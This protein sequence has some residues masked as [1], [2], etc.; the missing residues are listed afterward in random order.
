MKI[1]WTPDRLIV[2]KFFHLFC[3]TNVFPRLYSITKFAVILAAGANAVLVKREDDANVE[4][5]VVAT[6]VTYSY[7]HNLSFVLRDFEYF[8]ALQENHVLRMI[9]QPK[10]SCLCHFLVSSFTDY[11]RI[12]LNN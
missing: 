10:A 12:I 4:E 1:N 5:Y 9:F 6:A 3:A 2:F 7:N 11:D 8:K